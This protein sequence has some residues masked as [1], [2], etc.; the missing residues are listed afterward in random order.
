M[1]SRWQPRELRTVGRIVLACGLV[2]AALVYWVSA[3]QRVTLLD[4][5][6][7]LGYTRAMDAQMTRM[8][9]HLGVLMM[10]W[11]DSLT[12]PLGKALGVLVVAGL[13]AGYFFRIASVMEQEE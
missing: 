7:A 3:R 10:G 2:L 11:N 6:N 13:L 12:T 8:M 5:T 9:G 4:D 1:D